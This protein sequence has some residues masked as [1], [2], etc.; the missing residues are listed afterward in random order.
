MT[1]HILLIEANNLDESASLVSALEQ[2]EYQV[3]VAHTPEAAAKNTATLWPN[4]IIFNANNGKLKLVNF[5]NAINRI[6]L[7][8]PHIVVGDKNRLAATANSDTIFVEPG[9][10]QQLSQTIKTATNKQQDRFLRFPNL[11]VDCQQ[12][13]VLH[14]NN[15][16]HLTP[17]GYRLLHL[18]IDHQDRDLSRKAIMK[19]VWE[20]DYMGD[21]RTLDVHIRWLREKIEDDPSRPRRLIT[22]R[23]V[24]YRFITNP[25]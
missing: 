14:K 13:Q 22:I 20:T 3:V 11:I 18:L 10:A 8:V 21:T 12:R 2:Q 19:N 23:G 15:C 5:Q 17:K 16:F 25:E 4:L 24:G 7:N 9:N 6:S 1:I